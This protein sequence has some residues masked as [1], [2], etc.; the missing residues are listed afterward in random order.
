MKPHTIYLKKG[1]KTI[2]FNAPSFRGKITKELVIADE[3]RIKERR[4][5]P[6]QGW[7]ARAGWDY[8][9]RVYPRYTRVGGINSCTDRRAKGA[10]KHPDLIRTKVIRSRK[11]ERRERNADR[12]KSKI[13]ENVYFW[14]PRKHEK[15]VD[16]RKGEERRGTP[17]AGRRA[18]M[19]IIDDVIENPD[20]KWW[21]TNKERRDKYLVSQWKK[22]LEIWY[23]MRSYEW[24]RIY[25]RVKQDGS[26]LVWSPSYK[27]FCRR[28]AKR[29]IW[30]KPD[31][32]F[33]AEGKYWK[34]M[35]CPEDRRKAAWGGY[36]RA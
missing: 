23:R 18:E 20:I 34:I 15:T 35:R 25:K 5:Y 19:V 29:R 30:N 8:R 16:K 21:T 33:R 17:Y 13:N 28:E 26:N 7:M 9:G 3:R 32:A 1:Q 36:D 22:D 14:H 11:G 27:G 24:E 6:S 12:W 4:T 2:R 10:H 31:E